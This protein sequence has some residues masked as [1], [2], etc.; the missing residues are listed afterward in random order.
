V[1]ELKRKQI[2]E[3]LATDIEKYGLQVMHVFSNQDGSSFSY[4]I[5]LFKTY[6]HPEIIIIGLKQ[7]L[8]HILI[9]NMAEDIKNGK[10]YVPLNFY[11][12][13]LDGFECYI[14]EV[15]PNKYDEYIGQAQRYYKSDEFP[16]IQCIYP[17]IKGIFPWEKD[18]PENIKDLQPILGAINID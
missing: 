6:K 12:D 15:D 18:W 3:K 9:N 4:S 11:P 10:V 13:I 14:V 8:S 7:E 2:D 17:T 16:A 1:D 5:G